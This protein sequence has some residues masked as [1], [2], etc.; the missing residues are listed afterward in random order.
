M[1]WSAEVVAVRERR[2]RAR[3][4]VVKSFMVVGTGRM[5]LLDV[6]HCEMGTDIL[7]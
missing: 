5:W 1:M 6:S 3:R 2:V 4:L 7:S